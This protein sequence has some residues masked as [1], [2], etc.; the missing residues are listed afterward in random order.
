MAPQKMNCPPVSVLSFLFY[1]SFFLAYFPP[2]FLHC[3]SLH[4]FNVFDTL[5]C[6]V[7]TNKYKGF[8]G[9]Q[10]HCV[11]N[12]LVVFSISGFPKYSASYFC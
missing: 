8:V 5:V 3:T 11:S 6:A 10:H 2:T 1:F 4:F 12:L 9:N 7:I